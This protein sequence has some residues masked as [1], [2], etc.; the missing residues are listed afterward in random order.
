[1]K[2]VF[3]DAQYFVALLNDKDQSYPAALAISQALQGVTLVTT[4]E[5]LNEVLAFFAERGRYLRQVAADYVDDILSDP[6]MVI[7]PQSHQSFL[8]GFALYKA[9]PDKGYSLTDC[10]SME[11]MRAEGITEILTHD[12]HFTQE[13][14]T[15]LL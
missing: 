14:F 10:I 3:A 6:D 11:T 4:E 2:K 15:I 9:R 12:N 1:M 13:G 5:T 7:H 8:H